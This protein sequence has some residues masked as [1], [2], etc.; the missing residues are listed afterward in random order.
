LPPAPQPGSLLR[1]KFFWVGLLYFA[2][3]FPLG[4]FYEIFPV[5]FRQQGI[6]LRQ[7]GV[8]SL[9]GLAWTLKFLWAPAVDYWRHHRRWMAAADVLMGAVMI[10]FAQQAGFGPAVWVAIGIFTALSATNDIAVDGY[11]IEF[12]RKDEM[13]LANGIRIGLYRVGMLASGFVLMASEWLGW[14]GAFVVAAGLF[15]VLALA[16]LCAPREQTMARKRANVRSE[17]ASLAGSPFALAVIGAFGL[18]VVW[19]ID[20]TVGWSKDRPTFW[21]WALAAT[22]ILV[23]ALRLA[24]SPQRSRAHGSAVAAGNAGAED[25]L[26]RGALFGALMD[27]AARPG[28]AAVLAFI[29]I[30]KLPDAA[31]GFMVKP[32]WVDVGFSA[33]EIGLV[34]VNVGLGLSIAGGVVGGWITDRIGIFRGLWVLGLAQAASNLGYWIAAN[35]IPPAVAGA[36]VPFG[37]KAL[38]YGASAVESFTGGLGT[39]AFLAFLMAI[40]RKD[41]AATEYALLSSV[42]AL[43]RSV[44]GWVGGL[45]AQS[46]GYAPWFLLTFFLAF[47]AYALLPWVRRELDAAR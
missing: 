19:L 15:F 23:G 5:Y 3:G 45:G 40:V 41:R 39:A 4:V 32:F 47:P 35:V 10:Y 6:E 1:N 38:L 13:G 27:L 46:M 11:T 7:I 22:A 17:L 25:A 37:H 36:M 42:F 44:A 33:A 9:L 34:S 8:L 28:I 30:F 43:S 24:A 26:K 12:L 31:M 20:G 29:L 21:L 16:C 18:G 14:H 2:E